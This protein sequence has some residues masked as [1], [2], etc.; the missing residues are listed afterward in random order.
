M[1]ANAYKPPYFPPFPRLNGLIGAGFKA[2]EKQLISSDVRGDQS[3]LSLNTLGVE[4]FLL[5]LLNKIEVVDN[6]IP[7]TMSDVT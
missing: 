6:G 1:K 3:K 7:V 4:N 5:P 2:F